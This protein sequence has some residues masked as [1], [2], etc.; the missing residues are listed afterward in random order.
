[1]RLKTPIVE[2]RNLKIGGESRVA[3]QAM[4]DT[5]TEDATATAKQCILL[6]NAGAELVRIT[7]NTEKAAEKVSE[8]RKILDKKGYKS[9]PIIGDF[10]FNGHILL[11]KYPKCA[12]TL[13]KYRINPGNIGHGKFHDENFKKIIRIAVKNNKPI[14][15]GVNCGS[16]D[17]DLLSDMM[18]K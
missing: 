15:I 5:D 2:I 8:I 10:H 1:M 12:S 18:N 4:T 17:Q 6:A 11:S 9:L 14:R 7:V 3:I 13:D 16:L